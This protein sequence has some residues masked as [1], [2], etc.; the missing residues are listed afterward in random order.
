MPLTLPIFKFVNWKQ[1]QRVPLVIYEGLE[2]ID[3]RSEGSVR[4]GSNAKE[5]ER[6]YSC[7][8]GA[9]LMDE[10]IWF[11]FSYLVSLNFFPKNNFFG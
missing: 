9:I 8:F 10:K 2:A 1:T 4:A 11:I 3:V 7:S 6:Q 5:V